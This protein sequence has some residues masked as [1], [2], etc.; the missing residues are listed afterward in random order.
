MEE[1][2]LRAQDPVL[3]FGRGV[4]SSTLME[5]SRRFALLTQSAPAA[6]IDPIARRRAQVERMIESL[7]EPDLRALEGGLPDVEVVVGIGGGMVMDAAKYVAWQRGLPLV[8]APSIV[9]ADASVTNTIAVRRHDAV[10][11]DGF[12]VA[13]AILVDFDLIH[14]APLELNRAGVGDLVSI[15]TALFDWRLGANRGRAVFDTAVASRSAAVLDRIEA[16]ANEIGQV[17]DAALEAIMRAYAEINA[18]CLQ[19][20]HSQLQEGSEHYFAYHLE[21]VAGH[22]FVHGEVLSLGTLLMSTLQGNDL[23]RAR[24][25]LARSGVEWNLERLG[26][27]QA[28]VVRTL[29]ELP[30]FVR[31]AGLPYSIVDAVDM[32][33]AIAREVLTAALNTAGPQHS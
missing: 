9:S 4:L 21:T 24:R 32:T 3:R 28:D 23:D 6:S 20:G 33:P 26:V 11:Y 12:V 27:S 25:I 5:L 16:I 30:A 7:A 19:V 17:T 18:L 1:L 10:K 2:R 14:T 29:V 8:L 13:E 31:S 15:H 22:G